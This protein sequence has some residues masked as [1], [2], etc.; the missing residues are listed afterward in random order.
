MRDL[1]I[2]LLNNEY[3]ISLEGFQLFYEI[4]PP[5]KNNWTDINT[6]ARV[7]ES[8]VYLPENWNT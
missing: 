2:A 3:G 1:I 7:T 6:K 4:F 8:R 5:S